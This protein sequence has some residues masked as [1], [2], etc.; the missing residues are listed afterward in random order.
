VII[1]SHLVHAY[2]DR[3]YFGK[4]YWKVH[5][6]MDSAY[7]YFRGKHR[8]FWHD[9]QSAIV[10]AVNS[11]PNDQN[12]I[13]SALLH[14]QTDDACSAN[15]LLRIQLEMLAEAEV[16]KRRI[17]REKEKQ[18]PLSPEFEKALKDLEKIV[19]IRKVLGLG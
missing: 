10:I 4:V 16:K 9:Q 3:L 2:L 14:I 19:Q 13:K 8:I 12:A 11:Y 5:R 6:L 1:P 15:P 7:P 17:R 18:Q